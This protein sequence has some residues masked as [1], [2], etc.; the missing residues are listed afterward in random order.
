[1]LKAVSH[2][3]VGSLLQLSSPALQVTSQVPP[4]HAMLVV[5][6]FAASVVGV[7]SWRQVPQFFT[8]DFTSVSHATPAVGG[9]ETAPTQCL[10]VWLASLTQA[11]AHWPSAHDAATWAPACAPQS[12]VHEP[13]VLVASSRLHAPPQHASP[14]PQVAVVPHLH[15]PALQLSAPAPQA[16]HIPPHVLTSVDS[17]P[18]QAPCNSPPTHFWLPTTQLP[19][20]VLVQATISPSLHPTTLRRNS[21]CAVVAV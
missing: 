4:R 1:V 13:H 20:S 16:P 12:L 11:K 5:V 19:P 21:R 7:Q 3:S 8:S 10:R 6:P 18:A 14:A 9:V 15:S 2:P 17:A